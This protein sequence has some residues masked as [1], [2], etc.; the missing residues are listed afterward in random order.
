MNKTLVIIDMQESFLMGEFPNTIKSCRREI[1]KAIRNNDYIVLVEYD[2]EGPTIPILTKELEGY[3]RC[4]TCHKDQDSA[5]KS[6]QMACTRAGYPLN[7]IRICG[8]NASYCVYETVE[9]LCN[10]RNLKG[11]TITVIANAVNCSSH[12]YRKGRYSKDF[13]APDANV[14]D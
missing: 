11:S 10:A 4:I 14:I 6:I 7:D 5:A 3:D 13:F 2:D 9:G 1:R 12:P 8:V